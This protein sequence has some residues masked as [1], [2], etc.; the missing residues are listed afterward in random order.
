M[1]AWIVADEPA[2]GVRDD[3]GMSIQATSATVSRQGDGYLIVFEN[4]SQQAAVR[5]PRSLLIHLSRQIAR[6]LEDQ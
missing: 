3:A 4:T 5:L 1:A 6:A 2:P